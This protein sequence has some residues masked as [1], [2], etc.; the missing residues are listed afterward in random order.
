M[1]HDKGL[2][3]PN[4]KFPLCAFVFFVPLCEIFRKK[5]Y[6]LIAL[7]SLLLVPCSLHSLSLDEALNALRPLSSMALGAAPE[8]RWDPFFRDGTFSLGSHFGT[9][10]AAQTE[11]ENGF[12]M[13]D[14]REVLTVPLSYQ[15]MGTLVFPDE[16][17]SVLKDAFTRSFE[18][19]ASR[20]RIA[21]IVIDPGHGGRDP[22]AVSQHTINGKRTEIREKDIVLNVSK[23]LK[24]L[25]GRAYPDKRILMTRETDVFIPLDGRADMANAIPLKDNETIIFI[26]IHAN[27]GGNPN[28]RG[29]EVWNLPS[30]YSR[31]LLDPSKHDASADILAIRNLLME[32]EF[33]TESIILANS[34]LHGF[35]ENLGSSVP[36]RGRKEQSWYV[37]SY[38]R[39]PAV[40][41]ELGFLSN[42]EDALLMTSQDGLRKLSD[43]IYKGIVDFVSVF[44]RRGGFTL[45]P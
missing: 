34:I 1:K 21:A 35:G 43:A 5:I 30:S 15:D 10:T 4:S 39:M 9:F 40:L 33:Y 24:N 38:S 45:A 14:S 19:S 20:F 44:E 8:F 36:D 37:V 7:F 17:V 23:E 12:L 29:Y 2:K 41:V 27:W 6:F 22:G 11:G 42:I 31:N 13:L 25:L 3:L 18:D 16:F 32:E 26:S 28:S